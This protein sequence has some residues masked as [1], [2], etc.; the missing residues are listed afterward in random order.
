M[1]ESNYSNKQAI[2]EDLNKSNSLNL[3]SK[4]KKKAQRSDSTS[5]SSSVEKL[6]E[7]KNNNISNRCYIKLLDLN[8]TTNN[9]QLA[10]VDSKNSRT[11][12]NTS[13]NKRTKDLNLSVDE[14][15]RILNIFAFFVFLSFVICLNVIGLFI[16]P[17]FMKT[18]LTLND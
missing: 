1:N 2:N 11:N 3:T 14:L 8:N 18:A 15:I 12:K 5:S 7:K 10:A 9:Q 17:Y 13:I 6:N 16:L 4:S